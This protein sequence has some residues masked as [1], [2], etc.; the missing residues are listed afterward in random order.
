MWLPA[1]TANGRAAS[2]PPAKGEA[3]LAPTSMDVLNDP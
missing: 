1:S 2:D 3:S